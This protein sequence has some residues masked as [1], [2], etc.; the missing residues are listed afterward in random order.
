MKKVVVL[1]VLLFFFAGCS[2]VN[3]AIDSAKEKNI[4][5]GSDTWGGKIIFEFFSFDCPLPNINF[6]FGRTRQWY[7]SLKDDQSAALL[8]DAVKASNSAISIKA[9]N[10]GIEGENE[11]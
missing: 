5:A 4:A 1:V 7:I 10:K 9:N 6:C 11:Q 8:S 2:T 3:R